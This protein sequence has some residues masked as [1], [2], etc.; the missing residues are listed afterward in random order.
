MDMTAN[1]KILRI[2]NLEAGRFRHLSENEVSIKPSPDKWSK[3]EILGHLIDS[4]S[5]NHQRFVRVL[6]VDEL[7]S[8]G[9]TQNE[10][11]RLQDYAHEDWPII[12][13]LWAC[14]NQHLAHIISRV[15]LAKLSTLCRI[16]E[17]PAITL[18]TLINDYIKHMEHH[19]GQIDPE[20]KGFE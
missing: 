16:G 6:Q 3:K 14:L 10:W 18:E 1:N 12:V 2:I 5:N 20:Y 19:L 15:P 13:D 4:A 7:L 8:P 11:V 9:Y 17:R